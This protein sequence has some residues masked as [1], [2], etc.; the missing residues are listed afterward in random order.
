MASS[1]YQPL[2][3]A[4]R[5]GSRPKD[6]PNYRVLVH[7]HYVDH[8]K[9]LVDAVGLQQ[10]QQFWDHI[11]HLPD[12]PPA[13]AGSCILRGRAGHPMGAGWSR[14]VHYELSSMARA[15]YQ[16]HKTF[17][18]SAEGDEHPIVAIMTINLSS[19]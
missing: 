8:Y 12:Q 7:R 19:H 2:Q 16:Y 11:A 3:P 1:A 17:K 10:A 15:N 14:T 4:K 9:R 6:A 5:P 13:I 18:T